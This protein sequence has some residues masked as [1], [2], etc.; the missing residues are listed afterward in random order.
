MRINIRGGREIAVPQPLLNHLHRDTVCQKQTGARVAQIVKADAPQMIILQDN[1]ERIGEIIRLEQ[2]AH[3][4][5]ADV[6]CVF[7]VVA[8]TAQLAVFFLFLLQGQQP[9]PEN[10]YKRQGALAG[11]GFCAIGFYKHFFSVQPNRCDRVA[12]FNGVLLKVHSSPFQPYI[13]AAAQ[14]IKGSQ[15]NCHLNFT[16]AHSVEQRVHFVLAVK[17]PG[18]FVFL[19]AV[20][21]VGGVHI[22]QVCFH[23]VF[24]GAVDNRM[25]VNDRIGLHTLQLFPIKCLD[26]NRFQ[27]AQRNAEISKVRNDPAGAQHVLSA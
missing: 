14:T 19:W 6:V 4:V 17:V 7:F 24:Q 20:Y 25:I 27:V 3:C 1:L 22:D 11:F 9:F 5:Y 8:S 15:H 18:K 23:C 10:R 16:A 2:I 13:L 21:L 26:M 12:D